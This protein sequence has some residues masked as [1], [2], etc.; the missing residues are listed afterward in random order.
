MPSSGPIASSTWITQLD[1]KQGEKTVNPHIFAVCIFFFYSEKLCFIIKLFHV[2][3]F[4]TQAK[5]VCNTFV[6]GAILWHLRA[7]RT[8]L[9]PQCT[10]LNLQNVCRNSRKPRNR[11]FSCECLRDATPPQGV[12]LT[13][14]TRGPTHPEGTFEALLVVAADGCQDLEELE[15]ALL[16]IEVGHLLECLLDQFT[17]R[18]GLKEDTRQ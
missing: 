7:A 9:L 16:V 18:L 8:C 1:C 6:F 14:G 2:P 12:N 5:A 3:I 4:Y 10:V 15:D 11:L 13:Q 17:K